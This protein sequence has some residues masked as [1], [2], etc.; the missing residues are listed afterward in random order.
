MVVAGPMARYMED[1]EAGLKVLIG[2]EM[3]D[4]LR[5]NEEVD[6][7]QLKLFYSLEIDDPFVSQI[8]PIMKD[9]VERSTSI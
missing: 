7:K 4:K 5:L 6:V 1:I 8:R 9:C 3:T 2:K